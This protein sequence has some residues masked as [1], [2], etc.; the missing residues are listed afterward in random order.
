MITVIVIGYGII[1]LR[2]ILSLR[3]FHAHTFVRHVQVVKERFIAL[4]LFKIAR[5]LDYFNI[6]IIRNRRLFNLCV[7]YFFRI[8]TYINFVNTFRFALVRRTRVDVIP[9]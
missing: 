7:F 9:F 3:I 1:H 4:K 5:R 2:P 6:G 8:Q